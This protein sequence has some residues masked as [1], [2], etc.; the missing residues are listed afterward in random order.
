M[1]N[2]ISYDYQKP[3]FTYSLDQFISCKSDT[4]M[5]YH[6]LSFCDKYNDIIYDTYNVLGDY[7]DEIKEK[8]VNVKLS[9]NQ[10]WFYKYRPKLLCHDTY[11]NGEL[12]FIIL[13]INDM[14]NTK[15]FTKK[16]ILMPTKENMNIIVTQLFNANKDN[17]DIYNKSK[18]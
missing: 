8:C 18:T 13:A 15:Q 12:A 17:I 5:S 2:N 9:N 10:Y 7:I 16:R 3:Y 11:G 6:N 14:Y 4:V 1:Y